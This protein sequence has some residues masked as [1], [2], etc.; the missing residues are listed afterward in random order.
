MSE[1][2]RLQL[3][4]GAPRRKAN[5]GCRYLLWIG[6]LLSALVIIGWILYSIGSSLFIFVSNRR[7]P[8]RALYQNTRLL[9]SH[10]DSVVRPLIDAQQTFDIAVSVWVR[11]N[12]EEEDEHRRSIRKEGQQE[13]KEKEEK[14]L[15]PARVNT[16][17]GK[18]WVTLSEKNWMGDEDILETP[19]YSDI[20]FRG[21]R[22]SDKSISTAIKFRLPTARLY[23]IPGF[24]LRTILLIIIFTAPR[25]LGVNLTV[26]DLRASFVLIPSS[27][28]PIDH[29][30]N[31]SSWLSDSIKSLPHR[32]WP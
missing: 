16:G 6:F 21:L 19:L 29:L 20:V 13:K 7:F 11:A 4:P 9:G 27:P 25:S 8:H 1:K 15:V 3:D 32:A 10:P 14:V 22:L 12:E 28:S 30:Q 23:V 31:Y 2:T 24:R 18:V 17:N 26:H 5:P